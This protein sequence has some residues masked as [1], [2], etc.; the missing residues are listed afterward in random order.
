MRWKKNELSVQF[1]EFETAQAYKL[2][3]IR[4]SGI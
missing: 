2:K 4:K 1:K 3:A